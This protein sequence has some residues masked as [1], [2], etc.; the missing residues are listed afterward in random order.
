MFICISVDLLLQPHS[1][2]TGPVCPWGTKEPLQQGHQRGHTGFTAGMYPAATV[3]KH[4]FYCWKKCL[5]S[6]TYSNWYTHTQKH[7]NVIIGWIHKYLFKVT[8]NIYEHELIIFC[9]NLFI[10][11]SYSFNRCD[12]TFFL[13]LVLTVSP[14][15]LFCQLEYL[16]DFWQFPL[17]PQSNWLV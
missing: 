12:Y 13:K 9:M 7:T 6:P 17:I 11:S 2:P 5:C 15:C 10:L 8:Q 3:K 1:F 4:I 16:R 14:W